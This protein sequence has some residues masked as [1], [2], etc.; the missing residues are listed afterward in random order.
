MRDR[1]DFDTDRVYFWRKQTPA[2]NKYYTDPSESE[3]SSIEDR[4]EYR[5]GTKKKNKV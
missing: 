5:Q 4:N 2:P 1:S 3:A